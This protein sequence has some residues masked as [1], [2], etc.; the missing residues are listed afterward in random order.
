MQKGGISWLAGQ[1]GITIEKVSS[2]GGGVFAVAGG[3]LS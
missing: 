2:G 3:R 1:A